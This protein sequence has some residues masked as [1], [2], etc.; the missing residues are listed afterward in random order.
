MHYLGHRISADGLEPLP[1]KLDAI[2]NL[3]PAKNVDEAFQILGLLGYYRS[4]IPAF[5]D[6]TLP[7]TNLLKKIHLS[8]GPKNARTCNYLKE[9]FCNKPILQFPDPNKDYVLYTDALNNAYS[10]VLC[11][12]QSNDKDIRPVTYFSGTFRAQNKCWCATKKEAYAVLKSVQRFDYYL[13]G[14][15]CTL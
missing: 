10:S 1:E 12:P 4:F 13:R 2:K 11:Q 9:I 3:A 5:A 14:A 15:K 7:I 8:C 6:I